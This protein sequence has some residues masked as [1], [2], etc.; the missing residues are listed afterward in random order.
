MRRSP[1]AA[2][3]LVAGAA[4]LQACTPAQPSRE[5]LGAS[6]AP[7]PNPPLSRAPPA[8]VASSGPAIRHQGDAQFTPAAASI[9][10]PRRGT[11]PAPLRSPRSARD[12]AGMTDGQLLA[13]MG[14]PDLKRAEEG[15]EA[16]LYRSQACLLDVFLEAEKPGEEPRVVLATARPLGST[17]VAEEAC[18]RGLARAR[19]GLRQPFQ[20]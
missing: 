14:E 20:P 5:D 10:S 12:L 18:L 15:A 3:A 2:L 11:S 16:W 7:E 19:A 1:L 17:Q 9:P 6:L 4:F 8:L 13:V